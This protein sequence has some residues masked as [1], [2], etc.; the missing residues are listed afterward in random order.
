MIIEDDI[1]L[2]KE[3]DDAL[4]KEVKKLQSY[5]KASDALKALE[6]Y[7]PDLIITDI[8]IEN[9]NALE[10]I[11]SIRK[12]YEN[13]PIIVVSAFSEPE[14]FIKSIDL[15]VTHYLTKPVDMKKLKQAICSVS[16]QLKRAQELK[17]QKIL[18]KQYKHIVDLSSNITITDKKGKITYTNDAFCELSGYTKEELMGTS[19]NIVRHPSVKKEF[20][21]DLWST[22]AN[23]GAWQGVIKNRR[24][25]GSDF[26]VETTIAPLLDAQNEIIEYI[27]IKTNVTA[28]IEAKNELLAQVI[29]DSLTQLPNRIKLQEDIKKDKKA[30]LIV[31]DINRFKEI[32]LLFGVGLGDEVLKYFTKTI[33][34]A[35]KLMK[36]AKAY[37]ISADEFAIYKFGDAREEFENFAY[38]LNNAINKEPFNYHD[39]SFE[40]NFTSAIAYK[41]E[42]EQSLLES[43]LDA[44]DYAKK[45][46]Y[47]IYIFD[48]QTSRQREYKKNF[49]WTKKIKEALQENRVKAYFQAIYSAKE[50]KIVKYESLVR[51]IEKDG[52]VVSPF[53]FLEIAKHS[54][55]YSQI[56]K[57][58]IEQACE[59]FSTRGESVS[60]N[61]SI[62][63]LLDDETINFFI[64]KVEQYGMKNRIIAE[65]LE[66]EG[67]EN[68][69]IFSKVIHRLK[70]NGIRVAI[71]DFG[72]GYSNFSYLV[73]LV[74]DIL[75]IDGSLIRFITK[76]ANSKIIVSAIVSFAH[77]LG[78]Q[79]V[80]EFVSD[81]DIFEEVKNIGI[82]YIQGYYVSEPL[83][84]PLP[85]DS[86][87]VL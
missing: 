18:L 80:A 35:L 65:V 70:E 42:T 2:R 27:S 11:E 39:I 56:T 10:M 52:T 41:S 28:I 6:D 7:K 1:K 77:Q 19:H 68:F 13:I 43:T 83:A 9:M 29:T 86:V 32:N 33:L 79:T 53:V 4:S 40:T 57:T 49:E 50:N 14:Y 31:L 22:L 87:L 30:T 62:E 81:K 23:K 85:Q 38:D 72:S 46:K 8:K 15:K 76:D 67:V 3:F 44:L 54:N 63:D 5:S 36:G 55:L 66:S 21:Q 48:A 74:I 78:M 17:E 60:I 84:T 45:N 24:K 64:D 73:S 59:M 61:F 71:D 12:L 47:S 20:Y 58:V 37:R 82:D 26:Y 75:K 25:D 51:I 16:S 69:D 34:K